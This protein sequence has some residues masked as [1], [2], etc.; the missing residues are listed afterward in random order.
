MHV[1]AKTLHPATRVM[2][3]GGSDLWRNGTAYWNSRAKETNERVAS[4]AYDVAFRM[5]IGPQKTFEGPSD[6]GALTSML[7]AICQSRMHG[8]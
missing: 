4:T 2:L 6:Q 5:R 7:P 3:F 8:S 1:H